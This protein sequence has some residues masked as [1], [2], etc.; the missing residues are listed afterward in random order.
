MYKEI[1]KHYKELRIF[2]LHCKPQFNS[3]KDAG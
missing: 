3:A 1:E 2:A